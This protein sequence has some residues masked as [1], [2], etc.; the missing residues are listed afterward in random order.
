MLF[1]IIKEI[2]FPKEI[3]CMQFSNDNEYIVL[4]GL[5]TSAYIISVSK[6]VVAAEIK[7]GSSILSVG[8]SIN[9]ERLALGLADGVVSF[10]QL[11]N[12]NSKSWDIVG[13]MSEYDSPVTCLNWSQ[14]GKYLAIGRNDATVSIHDSTSVF[15]NFYMPITEISSSNTGVGSSVHQLEFNPQGSFLGTL[16]IS[17]FLCCELDSNLINIVLI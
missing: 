9:D 6:W 13:E 5:G 12:K 16:Y 14:N 3:F 10:I 4:G 17:F 11:E 2:K 7:T 15:A 8:Y 1:T